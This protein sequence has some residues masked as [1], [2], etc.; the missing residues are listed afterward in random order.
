LAKG[1]M[2][3]EGENYIYRWQRTVDDL[4]E[5]PDG[6]YRLLALLDKTERLPITF[7]ISSDLAISASFKVNRK[8]FLSPTSEA[9]TENFFEEGTQVFLLGRLEY[10]TPE[11]EIVKGGPYNE[12]RWCLFRDK[13]NRQWWSWCGDFKLGEGKK[14]EDVPL[15]APPQVVP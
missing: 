13:Q 2:V 4:R 14:V 3:Q 9:K 15:I 10:V 6:G 1:D 7:T 11:G 5:L 12:G 8:V